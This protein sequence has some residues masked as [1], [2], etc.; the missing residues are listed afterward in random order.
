MVHFSFDT[1]TDKSVKNK[2]LTLTPLGKQKVEALD[3]QGETFAILSA[4]A[5]RGPSTLSE[6]AAESGISKDKCKFVL[7]NLL[8]PQGFVTIMKTGGDQPY[9]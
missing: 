8:I 7:K 3:G 9:A 5:E 4:L 1:S 2:I 6:V